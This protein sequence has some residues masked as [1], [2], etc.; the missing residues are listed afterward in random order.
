MSKNVNRVRQKNNFN[1]AYIAFGS[2]Y[3][4]NYLSYAVF[5]ED[6]IFL[7]PFRVTDEVWYVK[8]PSVVFEL[9]AEEN[10]KDKVL[11]FSKTGGDRILKKFSKILQS[12]SF[13]TKHVWLKI[14]S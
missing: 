8:I 5:C 1:A 10:W 7:L 11:I 2:S 14:L 6:V 3:F 13:K 12:I 9:L 4:E